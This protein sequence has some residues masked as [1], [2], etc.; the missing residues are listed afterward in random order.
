MNQVHLPHGPFIYVLD[1][2]MDQLYIG[3]SHK[4]ISLLIILRD[5]YQ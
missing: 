1:T 5:Q 4:P 2:L 3:S